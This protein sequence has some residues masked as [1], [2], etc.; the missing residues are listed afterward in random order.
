MA[1]LFSFNTRHAF[2]LFTVK[3]DSGIHCLPESTCGY[4]TGRNRQ[5]SESPPGMVQIDLGC[6]LRGFQTYRSDLLSSSS[7]SAAERYKFIC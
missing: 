7:V 6:S 4:W 3:C 2:P 1:C 5:V